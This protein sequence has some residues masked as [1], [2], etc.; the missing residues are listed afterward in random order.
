MVI[1]PQLVKTFS[2]FYGNRRSLYLH[3]SPP[4]GPVLDDYNT[5]S[6]SVSHNKINFYTVNNV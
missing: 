1:L 4:L 3:K 2:A 5:S 6:V